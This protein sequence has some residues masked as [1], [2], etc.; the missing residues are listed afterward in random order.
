MKFLRPAAEYG[1]LGH[2]G[3]KFNVGLVEKKL[4]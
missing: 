4:A 2:R 1:L 3:N